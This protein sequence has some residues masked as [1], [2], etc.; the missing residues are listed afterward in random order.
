[1]LN[2]LGV[3]NIFVTDF[4]V[5]GAGLPF[6]LTANGYLTSDLAAL[7]LDGD[8]TLMR[9]NYLDFLGRATL[10]PA[11]VGL[12]ALDTSTNCIAANAQASGCAGYFYFDGTH[13][14][15]QVQAAAYA[16]MNRQFGLSAA[17]PEPAGWAM[18]IAGFA[19]AGIALRARAVQPRLAFS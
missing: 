5:G 15:A 4:P 16:D 10:A 3:R 1:M 11:T 2:D 12:P 17:V 6:S 9:F 13:P 14:T 19:M 8:T 18:M 7:N